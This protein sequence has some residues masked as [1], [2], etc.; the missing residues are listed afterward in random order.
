MYTERF[1]LA[2]VSGVLI[3]A[4][5][6]RRPG[7]GK[8]T[9]EV[10]DELHRVFVDELATIRK[11]FVEVF[12]DAA[13]F[14]RLEKA[15]LGD[16]FTRYCAVAEKQ[17]DLEL[18][19]YGLWRGGDIVARGAFAAGGLAFGLFMVYTPWIPIPRTWDFF[20]LASMVAAPF[21]PDLQES[22]AKRRY[23][24]ALE[25]IVA[26]MAAAQQAQQL[27]EP[28]TARSGAIAD[29]APADPESSTRASGRAR[30]SV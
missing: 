23:R 9:P 7:L 21:I 13:Y 8:W 14:E 27:Y 20:I 22:L 12:E 2:F 19:D 3:A 30:D 16:C 24:K 15:L 4:A 6:R 29:A 11:T 1:S 26:D 25:A 18:R 28:L 17:T 10:R 5:E